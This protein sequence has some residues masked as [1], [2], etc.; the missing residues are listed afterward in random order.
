MFD[1]TDRRGVSRTAVATGVAV[2][3]IGAIVVAAALG[4]PP[5][6]SP[7]EEAPAAAPDV[8]FDFHYSKGS[9]TIAHAGG[10]P[11]PAGNVHVDVEGRENET[12]VS[13]DPNVQQG[14]RIQAGDR[15]TLNDVS[16]GTTVRIVWTSPDGGHAVLETYTVQ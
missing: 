2:L 16:Q 9:V 13:R 6:L 14:S 12:W 1:G 10:P 4:S 5:S 3:A 11:I 7:D 15:V 8:E